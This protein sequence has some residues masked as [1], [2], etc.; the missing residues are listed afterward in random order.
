MRVMPK[1]PRFG[2]SAIRGFHRYWHI[3]PPTRSRDSP[4]V[5]GRPTFPTG[6]SIQLEGRKPMTRTTFLM[7]A[8]LT[9]G[10]F[11]A[12]AQDT[13]MSFF[14]TSVGVGDGA[15]LGGLEGADA[16]CKKLAEAAGITS[17]KTWH[18]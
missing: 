18:A 16:H 5:I 14:V 11:A 8:M 1:R 15:N 17:S 12:G 9:A 3:E 2:K 4:P 7:A 6:G 13:A 10:T